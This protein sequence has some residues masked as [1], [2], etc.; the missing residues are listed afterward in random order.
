L[1]TNFVLCRKSTDLSWEGDEPSTTA[2][3]EVSTPAVE[4]SAPL[5]QAETVTP[6]AEATLPEASVVEGE[7]T[8]V[9]QPS[10][11]CSQSPRGTDVVCL[12]LTGAEVEGSTI[13]EAVP[14][15]G[16]VPEAEVATGAVTEMVETTAPGVA[17]EV[18][19]DALPEASL[20]VVVRSPEIQDAEPIHSAPMSEAATTSRDGLEL[21][22]DDLISPATVARNL[23]SMRWTE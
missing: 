9:M 12:V 21:L 23:E 5:P 1:T 16:V 7:Y 18:P 8:A 10:S 19:G 3:E 14:V 17:E 11:S 15:E 4:E 13:P 22:E 6:V 20:E 2:A